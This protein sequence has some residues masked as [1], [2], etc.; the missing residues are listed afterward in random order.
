MSPKV[1]TEAE[2]AVEPPSKS[3][4]NPPVKRMEPPAK[5]VQPLEEEDCQN[6]SG[7]GTS[8]TAPGQNSPPPPGGPGGT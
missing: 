5:S 4:V 7:G 3:V 6:I 2:R 8:G 1:R